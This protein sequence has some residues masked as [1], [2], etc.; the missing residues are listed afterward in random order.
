MS[1][2]CALAAADLAGVGVEAQ[3]ADD[4]RGAAARRA[5]AHQ[6]PHPREQL[7]ALER[8]HQVVVGAGVE[9]L[10]AI[11]EVGARGQDQDRDVGLG[12]QPPADLDPVEPGQ[13]EVED[14]EVGDE[15]LGG[16]QRVDPVGRGA[17]LVALLAQRAAQDVGDRLVVLDDE[18]AAR[19]DSSLSSIG[20]RG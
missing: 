13:A 1:S 14:D 20:Y 5:P 19:L 3:V 16:A 15:L 17:H 12:A 7:L 6:R 11:V 18:H 2:I 8:L 9:A 4:Q 10:D